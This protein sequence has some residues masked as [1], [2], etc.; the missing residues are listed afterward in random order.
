MNSKG[1]VLKLLPSLNL[2][3]Y[4]FKAR[5]GQLFLDG[6][7]LSPCSGLLLPIHITVCFWMEV[8]LAI[9]KL[10]ENF[11]PYRHDVGL[12]SIDKRLFLPQHFLTHAQVIT[13]ETLLDLLSSFLFSLS[14]T[15]TYYTVDI[16]RDLC[17]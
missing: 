3:D 8:L 10:D 1:L 5:R 4:H 13:L 15:R 16:S 12:R 2:I 11:P 17:L 14:Y 9:A 6:W 7:K